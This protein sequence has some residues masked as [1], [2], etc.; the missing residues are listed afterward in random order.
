ML[1]EHLLFPP[2]SADPVPEF[3]ADM[4]TGALLPNDRP[5]SG[6]L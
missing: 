2:A 4:E 1:T 5:E 6:A 3:I